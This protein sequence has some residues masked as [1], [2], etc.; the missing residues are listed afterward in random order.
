MATP[1]RSAAFRRNNSP[2]ARVSKR[3]QRQGKFV[4]DRN[5]PPRRRADKIVAIGL[6]TAEEL[7]NVG[8][9]LHRLY[10]VP[11]DGAFD[12]L[13]QAIGERTRQARPR[14]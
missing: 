4:H 3:W 5:S 9:G 10:T 12:D 6:L 14:T 11:E 7:R 13:L 1:T 2:L 8:T